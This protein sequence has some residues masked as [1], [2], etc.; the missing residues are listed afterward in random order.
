MKKI[1]SVLLAALLVAGCSA[2]Q[3]QTIKVSE[4]RPPVALADVKLSE[5]APTGAVCMAE[6]TVRCACNTKSTSE[7]AQAQLK[8][9]AAALGANVVVPRSWSPADDIALDDP[10]FV[11]ARA[12]YVPPAN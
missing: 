10:F 12:Y 11:K 4:P 3:T 9:E 7:A 2:L 5:M 6:I 1:H 8:K